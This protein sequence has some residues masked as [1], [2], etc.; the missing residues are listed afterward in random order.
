VLKVMTAFYAVPQLM[1]ARFLFS[2]IAVALVFRLTMHRLPWRS[3][4]PGCRPGAA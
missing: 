3:A 1:W 4:R 2:L